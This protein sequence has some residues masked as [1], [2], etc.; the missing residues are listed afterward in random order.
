MY[1]HPGRLINFKSI[2]DHFRIKS[3]GIY[4]KNES[5]KSSFLMDYSG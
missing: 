4:W 5:G 3:N 1:I 2:G